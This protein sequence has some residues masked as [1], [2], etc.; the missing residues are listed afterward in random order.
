MINSV[1]ENIEDTFFC[2]VLSNVNSFTLQSVRSIVNA[3][4]ETLRKAKAVTS[5][6][7]QANRNKK[8]QDV[9]A[10]VKVV[11]RLADKRKRRR[12]QTPRKSFDN[13]IIL[14][15]DCKRLT[16]R[17]GASFQL[18]LEGWI[19]IPSWLV[20]PGGKGRELGLSGV[21]CLS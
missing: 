20:L 16:K 1:I 8:K 10:L 12:V 13:K 17:S 7:A 2:S 3:E 6:V 4:A 9:T 19:E 5:Q 21:P 18:E 11:V 14:L 15:R